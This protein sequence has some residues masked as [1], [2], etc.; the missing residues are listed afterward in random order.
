METKKIKLRKT[1][2][3]VLSIISL[4]CIAFILVINTYRAFNPD[5]WDFM[6]RVPDTYVTCI[7]GILVVFAKPLLKRFNIEMSY[8]L[9]SILIIT[10]VLASFG[11][12][13]FHLYK[14][15]TW[16]DTFIHL[17]TGVVYCFL[18]VGFYYL[19]NGKRDVNR[20]VILLFAV[21][22][23]ITGEV[24]WEIIE[25]IMDGMSDISNM[26]R[27]SDPVTREPYIGREAL[28]DTM[29]DIIL[30]FIG[31]AIFFVGGI[32]EFSFRK[33]GTLIESFYMMN[34]SP[35]GLVSDEEDDINE[36]E[37][38]DHSNYHIT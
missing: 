7:A 25:Y 31:S 34:T 28:Q 10:N 2:N 15:T 9:S 35:S 11:G 30:A 1:I 8:N 4:C 14:W 19:L 27:F 29:K 33:E 23:S 37:L 21:F 18:G 22:F 26:Q 17:L 38:Q 36:E 12:N 6:L 5:F 24:I 16:Y 13:I 3:L 32:I 20:I